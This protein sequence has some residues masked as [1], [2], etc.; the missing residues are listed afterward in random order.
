MSSKQLGRIDRARIERDVDKIDNHLQDTSFGNAGQQDVIVRGL[1]GPNHITGGR[2]DIQDIYYRA[3]Q[4]G[5]ANRGW[6]I[7]FDWDAPSTDY[8]SATVIVN[9]PTDKPSE[10]YVGYSNADDF[11]SGCVILMVLF[12]T[13]AVILFAILL[14]ALLTGNM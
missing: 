2:Q 11:P 6:R 10:S 12:G 14:T 1:Q 3:V 7:K 5:L 4:D 9:N 8:R 13:A